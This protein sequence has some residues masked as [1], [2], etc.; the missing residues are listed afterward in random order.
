MQEGRALKFRQEAERH[1]LYLN[2]RNPSDLSRSEEKLFFLDLNRGHIIT[3]ANAEVIYKLV[4]LAR[5]SAE[6]EECGEHI[7]LLELVADQTRLNDKFVYW[8]RPD[9][10]NYTSDE[11]WISLDDWLSEHWIKYVPADANL[12]QILSSGFKPGKF[13]HLILLWVLCCL[14]LASVGIIANSMFFFFAGPVIISIFFLAILGLV[15]YIQKP[16][17]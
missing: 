6:S 12:I 3:S 15:Y 17:K 1:G 5:A 4:Q 2:L 13:K 10:K 7:A 16:K 11:E 9:I 14:V 8:H